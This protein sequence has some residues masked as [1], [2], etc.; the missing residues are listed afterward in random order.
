MNL[1]T[2]TLNARK[3]YSQSKI[4]LIK[5]SI[6]EIEEL[7]KHKNLCIYVTGSFGR[8]E[9]TE[10]SDV[11]IFFI[12]SETE[13]QISKLSKTLIDADFIRL[14]DKMG[15]PPFSNDGQFLQIHSLEDIISHLGSPKDDF[16][17]YF[18]ARL[19]L[20]LESSPLYNEEFY[21]ESVAKM[22]ET[23]YRDFHRHVKDF[24][25]IFLVNDVIRY[26]KTLCLNYEH[27]RNT[28]VD[29][30]KRKL[31]TY[32]KNLKLVFSRKLT[33]YS[34]V[35]QVIA[36]YK[37]LDN[38]LLLKIVKMTPVERL[39]NLALI[40]NNLS[41]LIQQILELY[42]WFIDLC[43]Q[44]EDQL[45]KY[46]EVEANRDLAFEKGRSEF[47]GKL[48]DLIIKLTDKSPEI[49]KYLVI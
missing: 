34:F 27:R 45:F 7:K 31:K 18:T 30:G 44:P 15:F 14:I 19:L 46:I 28:E 37:S 23:Y 35:L 25:P 4:D 22:I 32:V 2:P 13:D 38:A 10:Y 24:L 33:C 42:S 5:A 21:D 16:S 20:L 11:D 39:N 43:N 40:D 3:E 6:Q 29:E 47:G 48:F 17:N 26:W 41:G 1:L 36:N 8:Q 12:N 9:A 49:L